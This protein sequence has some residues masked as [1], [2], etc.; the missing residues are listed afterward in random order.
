MKINNTTGS[1]I[2]LSILC[3][4]LRAKVTNYLRSIFYPDASTAMVV[5]TI[6]KVPENV[7]WLTLAVSFFEV[8]RKQY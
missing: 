8:E 5:Q 3:E 1:E 4:A 6:R 7:Q 2:A